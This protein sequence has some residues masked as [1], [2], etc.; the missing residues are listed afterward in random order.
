MKRTLVKVALV[1][2]AV[3]LLAAVGCTGP[4]SAE[5]KRHEGLGLRRLGRLGQ[6]E[7]AENQDG[8][9]ELVVDKVVAPGGAW[10]VVHAD[11]NGKP[12]MRVG[13]RA[14]TRAR[15]PT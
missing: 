13:S 10:I 14:S 15:A 1:A 11:D 3:A 5:E 8:V 4:Q 9:D 2:S 6:L 7:L 12:G